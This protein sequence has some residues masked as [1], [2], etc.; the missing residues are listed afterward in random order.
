MSLGY[1]VILGIFALISSLV[2]K[3]LKAKFKKYSQVHLKNGLSG[4]QIAERMLASNGIT[5]V[6]ITQ[7]AGSL[8]DHYN[9]VNRTVNLS[10]SV[11][12]G[13]N[14]ASAAVSA[15]EC[16][17][18][19]QHATA[20][21]MLSLRSKLVPIQNISGRILNIV[22]F[23]GA[24]LGIGMNS[25]ELGLTIILA[26]Y[27]VL[28]LF[29]IVTLPVEFDASK[30]ALVWMETHAIVNEQELAGAKDALKWAALTYVVAA[31]A[32]AVTFLYF[33]FRLMNNRR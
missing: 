14:A 30:R 20:Y 11:Y 19:V 8:T 12:Y 24:F 15:H 13:E 33:L 31:L 28:T 17:H 2:S 4:K 6:K 21:S 9:P 27:A 3:R 1:L 16:G 26:C 23:F 7:V 32:S 29:S 22:I 5:D 25:G 18:A 10:E